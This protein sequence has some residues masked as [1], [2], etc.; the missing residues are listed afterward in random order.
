[1]RGG[2][3]LRSGA[4]VGTLVV[5][6]V[7]VLVAMGMAAG[8]GGP[9]AVAGVTTGVQPAIAVGGGPV[10]P[11][12]ILPEPISDPVGAGAVALPSGEDASCPAPASAGTA[13]CFAVLDAG[14]ATAGYT[15]ASLQAAYGVAGDA[16]SGGLI[17]SS[18]G[19]TEAEDVAVVGAYNDPGV[20]ADFAAYRAQEGLPACNAST[21]AGC[22][23]AVTQQNQPS[24]LPAAPPA[25]AGDWTLEESADVEAVAAICPNCR[26]VLVE[27]KDDTIANLATADENAA[28]IA[29]FVDNGWGVP[30]FFGEG[31]DDA[32]FLNHPGKAVVF[33][34][35]N[36]GYGTDWPAA[37]QYVTAVG[38]T[39][40]T[41]DPS[42]ARGYAE[43]AWA[44]SG[45]GCA[46][47]EHKPAWQAADD[48]SPAGCLNR[49]QND[50]AADADPATGIA[51]YD[52]TA[53]AGSSFS[54]ATG[55]GVAGGTSVA[56]AIIT[57]TY[58]LAGYP[59]ED[60]YP[61]AYPYQAGASAELSPVTSGTNGTCEANRLYLCN[62]ADSLASGFNAPAG[63]GTPDGTTAL[64]YTPPA[65]GSNTIAVPNPGTQ[66]FEIS[67]TIRI[68]VPAPSDSAGPTTSW[69]WS[70][71]GLPSGLSISSSTGVITG[72]LSATPATSAVTVTATDI[73]DFSGSVTFDIVTMASTHADYH[74]E[75]GGVHVNVGSNYCMDDRNGGTANGTVVQVHICN[76]DA[77][78]QSWSWEPDGGPGGAGTLTLSQDTSQC[79][80]IVNNTVSASPE[81]STTLWSC[82]GSPANEQ[83]KIESDGELYST[84]FGEC[85]TDP[86][87][88]TTNDTQLKI[89][90][91]TD[92]GGQQWTLTP[93]PLQS[94]VTGACMDDT[95]GATS[96]GNKVQIYSCNGDI[97]SQ[98]WAFEP[99]GT[100]RI[101]GDDDCLNASNSGAT[102]G[103][104]V[105]VWSCTGAANQEWV[106]GPG[107]EIVNVNSGKCLADPGNATANGTQLELEDCYGLAGET[108]DAT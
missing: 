29:N 14:A 70:A 58:A 22:L 11:D 37:S 18:A 42:D 40:L 94:G 92:A 90:N 65:N 75:R 50:V 67:S 81:Y 78:A 93:G 84:E 105:Q 54:R 8:V 49:T 21:G 74:V 20:V 27:A 77:N 24:G 97:G 17:T 71:R 51:V 6:V 108:W 44:N 55:W 63:L 45:S 38:G 60:T 39:T 56:A 99:N 48:T 28:G 30:E 41:A 104:L 4:A 2:C 59:Q 88:S 52:S 15:P 89:G 101:Q 69:T 103:T 62:A 43:T 73:D 13:Q 25:A 26:V 86:G 7:P 31:S 32:A 64:A 106:I 91:C 12:A 96:N 47:D 19:T 35:G 80:A 95:G 3:G 1:M 46:T 9:A 16:V 82:S 34:A 79:L 87:N 66:D 98:D 72:T 76:T 10:G 36:A 83:W 68:T 57:A 53:Y 102:D 107:D 33:A 85:L 23:A 100:I 5:A 61:A